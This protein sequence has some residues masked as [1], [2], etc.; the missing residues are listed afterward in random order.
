SKAKKDFGWQPLA[1][2]EEGVKK[3]YNWVSKNKV[4]IKK[5]GVFKK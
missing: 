5:A 2:P 4:L 1:S 3:L